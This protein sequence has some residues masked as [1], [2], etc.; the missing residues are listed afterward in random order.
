[1][2]LE[3]VLQLIQQM[4]VPLLMSKNTRLIVLCME[5][6]EMYGLEVI[7]SKTIR[8]KICHKQNKIR[9]YNILLYPSFGVCLFI[10][11][12]L[13]TLWYFITLRAPEASL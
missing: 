2:I 6:M 5:F 4:G 7:G 13:V 1:M 3:S 10:S 9:K 11:P 12:M 8:I